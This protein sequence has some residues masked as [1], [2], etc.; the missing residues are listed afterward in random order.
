MN[1]VCLSLILFALVIAMSF[2]GG[3]GMPSCKEWCTKIYDPVCASNGE[4]LIT[5]S[6]QCEFEKFNCLND[7]GNEHEI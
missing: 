6:N 4:N 5:F 3:P 7:E 2:G 1:S